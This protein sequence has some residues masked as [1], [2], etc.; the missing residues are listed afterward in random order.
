MFL[1]PTIGVWIDTAS[2]RLQTLVTSIHINRLSITLSSLLWLWLV[3]NSSQ[4]QSEEVYHEATLWKRLSFVIIIVL[5]MIERLSRTANLISI[6]RD[7]VPILTTEAGQGMSAS[8]KGSH[9]YDLT[10]VNSTM[11][12]IDLVC[13]L[14]APIITSLVA[15]R[16]ADIRWAVALVAV[17]GLAT[18]DFEIYTAKLLWQSSTDLQKTTNSDLS[19]GLTINTDG[20]NVHNTMH[21]VPQTTL[22]DYDATRYIGIFAKRLA[23]LFTYQIHCLEIYFSSAVWMPSLAVSMLHLSVL[24]FSSILTTHFLQEGISLDMITLARVFGSVF[25]IASTFVTPWGV[26]SL[27]RT[28]KSQPEYSVIRSEGDDEDMSSDDNH[29]LEDREK[30]SITGSEHAEVRALSLIGYWSLLQMFLSLVRFRRL[31]ILGGQY[32]FFLSC[33]Q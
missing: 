33:D 2:S 21:S 25:E 1:A 10:L 18:W 27:G 19:S 6:E 32:P 29:I 20:M 16:V 14:V 7:W 24:A 3:Q 30:E 23:S 8:S 4:S 31:L 5:G 22:V 28:F 15:T 12:R 9:K 13:K 11:R 17:T 26:R